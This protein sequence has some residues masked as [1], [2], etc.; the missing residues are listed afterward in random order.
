MFLNASGAVRTGE[1]LKETSH[2]LR[3][4]NCQLMFS[5]VNVSSKEI[6]KLAIAFSL[7]LC[8]GVGSTD[9]ILR[10]RE[11]TERSAET[12][13][14]VK[15]YVADVCVCVCV[16]LLMCVCLCVC[17]YVCVVYTCGVCVC[18]FVCVVCYVVCVVCICGVCLCVCIYLV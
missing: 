10:S 16:C 7:S 11:V 5:R 3:L 6:S 18:L 17:M 4:N 15:T 13:R 8:S 12:D 9:G 2:D 14:Q 1:F